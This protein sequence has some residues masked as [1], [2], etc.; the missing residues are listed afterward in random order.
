MLKATKEKL[1][2]LYAGGKHRGMDGQL[3]MLDGIT[4]IVE[5]EGQV[6][7]ELHRQN[8]PDLSIEIGLAYGFSTLFILD[9][10]QEGEYGHHIAIDPGADTAWNGIGL[11]AVKEAGLSDRFHWIKATSAEA[12]PEMQRSGKRAQFIYID[13]AH[14]FDYALVDFFLA[15][16]LLDVGGIIAIDDMWM[17]ALK[18]MVSYVENNMR[19]HERLKS[20]YFNLAVFR[21]IGHDE[22]HW[23]HYVDF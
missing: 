2:A 10:M 22:R 12:L 15:D 23:D 7:A 21:K 20:S 4:R 1:D 19:W 9:A 16:K 17:P 13:G 18:R 11:R 6:L 14:L 5:E 3:Y 8:R